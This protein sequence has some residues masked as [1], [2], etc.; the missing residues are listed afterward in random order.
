VLLLVLGIL[1]GTKSGGGFS[2]TF[3]FL[4]MT[5]AFA[6]VGVLVSARLPQNTVGWLFCAFSLTIAFLIFLQQGAAYALRAA[7]N[8]LWAG[9]WAAWAFT[10]ILELSWGPLIFT[11]LSF[12]HSHLL[13]PRWR[14]LAWFAVGMI[15][16]GAVTSAFSP[17]NFTNNFPFA[18]SSISVVPLRV[19]RLMYDTYQLIMLAILATSGAYMILR[20]RRSRGDE[21]QQLKWFTY[22][23][24]MIIVAFT[25]T[26]LV[27]IEPVIVSVVICSSSY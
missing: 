22:T 18:Q 8:P 21:R 2:Q 13:S 3:A 11:F 4:P 15:L 26:A 7:P 24:G 23:V 5:M 20:L 19:A 14:P 16:I 1:L 25:V 10:W 17:V 9:D 27:G 12:P 6:T